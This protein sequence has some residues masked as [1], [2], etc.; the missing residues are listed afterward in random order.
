M[1]ALQH[2]VLSHLRQEDHTVILNAALVSEQVGIGHSTYEKAVNILLFRACLA[3]SAITSLY[4][5]NP[6]L[7]PV[8]DRFTVLEQYGSA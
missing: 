8:R 1:G 4:F 2:Y 5:V 7:V 3:K 6:V